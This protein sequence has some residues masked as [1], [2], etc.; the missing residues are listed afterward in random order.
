[1]LIYLKKSCKET[2]VYFPQEY[3]NDLL[4]KLTSF[5]KAGERKF[6]KSFRMKN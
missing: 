2:F 3:T 6:I 5:D 4:T 1:M